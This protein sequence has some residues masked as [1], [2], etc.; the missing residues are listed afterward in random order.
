[1][2]KHEDPRISDPREN[3]LWRRLKGTWHRLRGIWRRLRGTWRRL[4]G[5]WRRMRNIWCHLGDPNTTYILSFYN[6]CVFSNDFFPYSFHC[7]Y[8]IISFH[9]MEIIISYISKKRGGTVFC[10]FPDRAFLK[11]LTICISSY[12]TRLLFNLVG[13]PFVKN[14]LSVDLRPIL[15]IDKPNC[16]RDLGYACYFYE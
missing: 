4:R 3:M 7:I 14:S 15:F 11:D 5:T 8:H 1:M 12:S 9:D 13:S 16:L 10:S 2:Q 6:A